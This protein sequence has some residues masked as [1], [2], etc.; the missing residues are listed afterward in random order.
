MQVGAHWVSGCSCRG[1]KMCWGGCN[2]WVEGATWCLCAGGKP[3]KCIQEGTF[4][5]R[6]HEGRA[7]NLGTGLWS[8][9]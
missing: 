7:E 5:Q 4:V 3:Q 9:G 8:W 1:L 6:V 2:M